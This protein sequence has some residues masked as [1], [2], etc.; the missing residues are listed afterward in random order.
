MARRGYR[1]A[2]AVETSGSSESTTLHKPPRTRYARSGDV[3]IAYQVIGDGPIDLVFV[4]GWV[5]HIEMFWAE[6]SFARFLTRLSRM[7]RLIVFDKRGTGLSDRVPLSQLPSLEVRMDDVRAV[8]AAAGSRRAVLDGRFGGSAADGAVRRH[9]SATRGGRDHDRRIRAPA[10]GARLS[11]G[12]DRGA[13]RGVHHR[14]GAR[15]GRAARN[16]R[17]R[18]EPGKRSRLSALVGGLPAHGR[19]PRRRR[20][21]DADERRSR[22]PSRASQHSRADA[23]HS[24]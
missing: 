10:V 7:A 20:G 4:M 17:S 22:H 11:V 21:A 8:M 3:N 18:T 1:F 15:L 23:R 14:A 2:S 9:L 24:P 12:S 13:A 5:S 6:P 16:R 19:E